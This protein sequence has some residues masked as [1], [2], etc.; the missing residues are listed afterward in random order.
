LSEKTVSST[1]FDLLD[2][3]WNRPMKARPRKPRMGLALQPPAAIV[4]DAEAIGAFCIE[5]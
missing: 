5:S 2:T 3:G 1:K 4:G